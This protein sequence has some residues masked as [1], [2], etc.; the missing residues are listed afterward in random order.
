MKSGH[1]VEL[2]APGEQLVLVRVA[3]E[4]LLARDD[5]ERAGAVLP[6]L[7]RV[8]D[9]ADLAVDRAGLGEQLDDALSAPA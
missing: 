8:G 9:R 4:P 6:E 5:L 7:H 2:L 1:H 3:D